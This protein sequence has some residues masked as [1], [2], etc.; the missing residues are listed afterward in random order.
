M[1]FNRRSFLK[2]GALSAL[3]AAFGLISVVPARGQGKPQRKVDAPKSTPEVRIP[4][5]AQ[6]S[7]LFYF[8]RETFLPYVGGIFIVSAGINSVEMTLAEVT[9]YTPQAAAKLSPGGVGQ[10]NSFGLQFS[11]PRQLTD[12]TTIYDVRHGALGE[13]ALFM[14]RRDGPSGTSL[15]E[16]VFNHLA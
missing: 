8:T 12:L 15:Y 4:F 14:T 10:T 7:P 13:F 6:Q 3:T 11:S 2:S 5:G 1:S 16:A 9:D